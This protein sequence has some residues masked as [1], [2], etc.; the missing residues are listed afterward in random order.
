MFRHEQRRVAALQAATTLFSNVNVTRE[1]L[2]RWAVSFEEYIE[3]GQVREE[4]ADRRKVV[5]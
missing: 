3:K 5:V 2:L 4:D 1:K